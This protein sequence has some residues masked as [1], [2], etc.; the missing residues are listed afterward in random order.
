[1]DTTLIDPECQ[2]GR[3]QHHRGR[4]PQEVWVLSGL[5]DWCVGALVHESNP[6]CFFLQIVRRRNRQTLIS[7]IQAGVNAE[8]RLITD[9]WGAYVDLRHSGFGFDN[10]VV[11]HSENF[12]DPVDASIHTQT[13]ENL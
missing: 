6:L 1:M 3:R 4:I 13:I 5:M 7:V 8:S 9:G 10:H 2:V 11:N 12:V